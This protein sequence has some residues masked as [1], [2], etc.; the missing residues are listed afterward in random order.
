MYI[1]INW[2]KDFVDLNGIDLEKLINR[3]TLSVAEVE[4]I[5]KYGQNIKDVTTA[6]I[7]E[8]E[9][10]LNSNKLRLIKVDNGNEIITCLCGAKNI[11]IGDIV[12]FAKI[13]SVVN[14]IKIKQVEMVGKLSNGMCLSEKELGISE[15]NT[16][17]MIL[18]KNT[19]IGTDIKELMNIDDIV[20][21]IDNKSLTNR[22]DLWGHYGIAREIAAITGRKLKNIEIANL[23]KYNNLKAV[24]INVEDVEKCYRYT[25]IEIENVKKKKLEINKRI[26]LYYC[27]IRSINLLVDLTNYIMLEL[28]QPMHAY[29]KKLVNNI[30]IKSIDKNIH[31]MTLDGTLRNINKGTLMICNNDFPIAIAGIMGG[32]NSEITDHTSSLVL[33]SANFNCV[34]IRKSAMD[35]KLRTDASTHYEKSLDPTMT[36]I[37]IK[38]YIKLLRENDDN[39]KIISKL[40]DIYTKKFPEII[41]EITKEYINNRIGVEFS[42]NRIKEILRSLEFEVENNNNIL[43]I[44]VPTFRATKDISIKA[45]LVEEIARIYGYD[46]IK[47]QT[48][49]QPLKI[50][51]MEEDKKV[52][53][54][55]KDLLAIKYGL[56]EIHTYIWYDRKKNKELNI[57]INENNIKLTNSLNANFNI[58]RESIIPSLLYTL[59]ENIKYYSNVNIFECGRTFEYPHP[60]KEC[61]EKKNLGIILCSKNKNTKGLVNKGIEIV[62]DIAKLN[63]NIEIEMQDIENIKY[64]W[65]SPINS[66]KINYENICIGYISELNINIKD[67]IDKKANIVVLEISLDNFNKI[68][69]KKI[70]YKEISKYQSVNIDISILTDKEEKYSSLEKCISDVNINNLYKYELID[71][72]EDDK[73]IKDKKSVTIRF[74]LLS[75]DH[76]LSSG[77]INADLEQLIN[78]FEA[79]GYIIKR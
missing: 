9:K 61:I 59:N 8:I 33:E 75:S 20:F 21:E 3:F 28:G 46:N 2:I 53:N 26:R 38:R 25:T 11:Q 73:K 55:I 42:L 76:T 60:G 47:P 43:K 34:S 16:G 40:T 52:E 58:L 36:D 44:K 17:V 67:N 37:A 78:R 10:I 66:A 54:N 18:D 45:D 29:D 30:N 4:G 70:I 19:K 41:I 22:P 27:G 65:I 77:E 24:N 68:N 12:P 14:G 39:I 35:I 71:I 32:K 72:F 6:K 50:V 13:G 74:T 7:V 57:K 69:A 23:E 5:I 49:S 63:K 51:E 64:N 48:K 31:F 1:S 62:N 56:S 15:D 79:N